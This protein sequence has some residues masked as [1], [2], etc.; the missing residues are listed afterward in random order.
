[1]YRVILAVFVIFACYKWGDWKNWKEYYPTC[2]YYIVG[3]LSYNILFH[4]NMLW[5][6]RKLFT[7][8]FSDYFDAFFIA[9]FT[10]ILFLSHLPAKFINKVLYTLLWA[11][12]YTFIEYVSS[13]SGFIAYDNGWNIFWS[14]SVFGFIF[15]MLWLH[16][17]NPLLVWPISLGLAWAI[18]IIFEVPL[19][20]I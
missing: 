19:S 1:M 6:Y 7:H 20:S 18:L 2:L 17:K 4:E 15:P 12:L 8:T 3:D 10:V 9:P 16:H 11:C 13:L 5:E 14:F